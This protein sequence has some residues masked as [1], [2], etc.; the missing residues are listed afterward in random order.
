MSENT[1]LNTILRRTFSEIDEG[2]HPC[3]FR[4]M[5]HNANNV[6]EQD[7]EYKDRD[8]LKIIVKSFLSNIRKHQTAYASLIIIF[9]F[10]GTVNNWTS[11]N[12]EESVSLDRET[13]QLPPVNQPTPVW[14]GTT[15]ELMQI[16]LLEYQKQYITFASYNP[17]TME[18]TQ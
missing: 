5:F 2:I 15:D 12:L 1:Y 13:E 7:I 18:I 14:N 9:V 11:T 8:R 4:E 16:Q 3:D 6:V 10:L 17:I